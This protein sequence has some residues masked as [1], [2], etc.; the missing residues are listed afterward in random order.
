MKTKC[1]DIQMLERVHYKHSTNAFTD[2]KK[3]AR[4][5]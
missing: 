4:Y 5:S 2:I 1:I 3:L